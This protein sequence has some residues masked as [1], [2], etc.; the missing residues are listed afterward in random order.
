MADHLT[1]E[2][3]ALLDALD[4]AELAEP[5]ENSA[6][7]DFE[8]VT[9]ADR[10][11]LLTCGACAGLRAELTALSGRLAASAAD[12][13]PMPPDVAAA[14]DSRLAVE[15]RTVALLRPAARPGAASRSRAATHGRRTSWLVQAAAGVSVLA[16]AGAVAMGAVRASRDDPA[17]GSAA[18]GGMA[19]AAPD[20]APD[21]A[22]AA[23]SAA[24]GTPA[25]GAAPP[26]GGAGYAVSAS[27]TAYTASIVPER[28]VGLLAES[29]QS[30]Q[31]TS[32][33]LNAA[34][35]LQSASASASAQPTG[36]TTRTSPATPATPAKAADPVPGPAAPPV[37]G[38]SSPLLPG[39]LEALGAGPD[40]TPVLVDS[41]TWLG[42]PVALVVLRWREDPHRTDAYVVP[43]TCRSGASGSL[44]YA[45]VQLP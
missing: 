18:T 2:Q 44:F 39:C 40:R 45:G 26:T 19:A 29:P 10:E 17:S 8:T 32:S 21:S 28:V 36:A 33:R 30:D 4:D 1:A 43:R 7:S 41:G 22:T 3:I 20:S 9:P 23:S 15:A 14:L 38:S 25:G 37:A 16:L 27:G 13:L 5:A 42:E 24:A 35:Q 34:P 12:G 31:S 6:L 11:H